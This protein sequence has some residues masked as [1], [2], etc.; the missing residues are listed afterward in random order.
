MRSYI[1]PTNVQANVL[2]C[3]KICKL[4]LEFVASIL[5]AFFLVVNIMITVSSFTEVLGIVADSIA[6]SL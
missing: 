6:N 4:C 2:Q 3:F 5:G 1:T